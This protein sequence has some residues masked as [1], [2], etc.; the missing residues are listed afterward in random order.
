MVGLLQR[1]SLENPAI[2][3]EYNPLFAFYPKCACAKAPAVR[4]VNHGS[5]AFS[6]SDGFE[7]RS[8]EWCV[9]LTTWVEC[10]LSGKEDHAWRK[11]RFFKRTLASR[12]PMRPTEPSLL[13]GAI[14]LLRGIHE[15]LCKP[16]GHG[17]CG[18]L[19]SLRPSG[20][21]SDRTGRNGLPVLHCLLSRFA[22]SSML[23]G[24]RC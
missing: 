15:G 16:G 18:L 6:G 20:T 23:R 4:K 14:C 12:G 22:N 5:R 3:P 24:P 17:L 21:L 9:D 19:P 7:R 8:G 1:D 11:H 2:P 13:G 10:M